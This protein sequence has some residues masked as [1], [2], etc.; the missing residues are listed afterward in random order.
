[1]LGGLLGIGNARQRRTGEAVPRAVF[2][3]IGALS[4]AAA[5]IAVLWRGVAPYDLQDGRSP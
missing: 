5:G 2:A 4:F 3:S 1:V